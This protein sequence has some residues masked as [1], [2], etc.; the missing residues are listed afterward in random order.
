MTLTSKDYKFLLL[1]VTAT[2]IALFISEKIRQ[3]LQKPY[4]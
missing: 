1:A 3:Q 2:V 4:T